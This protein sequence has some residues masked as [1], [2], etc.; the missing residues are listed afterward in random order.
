MSN[1]P[2]LEILVDTELRVIKHL[3]QQSDLTVVVLK[4]HLLIEELLLSAV[5]SG[6]RYPAA[7]RSA[8]V[9]YYKLALF[10]KALFYEESLSFLWDAIFELNSLR[11]AFAHNLELPDM[12][13]RL[14]RFA[15]VASRGHTAA[16][17]L[18]VAQPEAV[19]ASSIETMC[20][21]LVGVIEK[22]AS[23]AQPKSKR[24]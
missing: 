1:K 3:S 5:L 14:R 6:V 17:D 11:N 21:M 13:A 22:H 10:A 12:E 16:G 24:N 15:T 20:G 18:L 2:T 4:G 9:G 19:M 23:T 7:F 8:T